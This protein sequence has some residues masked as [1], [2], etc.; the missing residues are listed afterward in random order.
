[1]KI[2]LAFLIVLLFM[3][4]AYGQHLTS[5]AHTGVPSVSIGDDVYLFLRHLSVRGVIDSYDEST[6]PLSEF[7]ITSLLHEAEG[8]D[9]SQAEKEN[10]TKY[11]RTYERTPYEA[12]TVFAAE[13][14]TRFF[15]GGIFEV[16]QD[17]YLFRWRDTATVSDFQANALASLEYRHR[18][19]PESGSAALGVIGGRFKGTL[20]G[21]VGFYMQT[22]NGQ[23]FGD[24]SI[25]L[26]DPVIG[27]N[28]NFADYSNHTFYDNTS[29]ELAYNNDWF[30]GKLARTPIAFGGGYQMD[31]VTINPNVSLYDVVSLAGKVK[32]VQYTAVV[33]SLLGDAR[34]SERKDSNYYEYGP[35][36]YIDPKYLALHHLNVSIG[37]DLDVGFTDMV[38]F[39][40]RFDLAYL[41]PFSFLKSVEHST[42]DR[43]NGLLAAHIRWR[44]AKG[45]EFRGQGLMDDIVASRIGD[46]Y[47]GN[48]FAWQAGLMWA[49]PFGL[50]DVDISAEYTQVQ[51]YT[52]SHFNPQNAFVTNKMILGSQIGPNSMSMWGQVRW[53]PSWQWKFWVSANYIAR[54]ENIYDST[55]ALLVNYGADVMQ[56]VSSEEDKLR[57]YSLLDGNR[58]NVIAIEANVVYEPFRGY[59]I[60]GRIYNKSV[61]YPGGASANPLQTP[62][63]L[64]TLGARATF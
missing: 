1:V 23:S 21:H 11:L 14:D 13:D 56:S 43:D 60:F 26:E 16:Y 12:V 41:N 18:G 44:F 31:N 57:S 47:W 39:S 10:I 37:D 28:K 7:E 19:V 2:V 52:Y 30:T 8:K 54:G 9:I 4:V 48:K 58:V 5:T 27:K 53:V 40:R 46:G 33:A 36:A 3:P 59:E 25:A 50:N 15:E 63:R 61:D 22:T 35:G 32:A 29:A 49:A 38:I 24:S 34:Y 55:G 17:K 64:F 6:L 51:P 62:Y 20:S 45:L 42:N